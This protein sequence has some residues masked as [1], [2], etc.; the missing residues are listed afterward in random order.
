MANAKLSGSSGGSSP[1]SK[2][3]GETL[4]Q[5]ESTSLP[6]DSFSNGCEGVEFDF[7]NWVFRFGVDDSKPI[8]A[9]IWFRWAMDLGVSIKPQLIDNGHLATLI[10]TVPCDSAIAGAIA[11]GSCLREVYERSL[12]ARAA[13]L[14]DQFM[15]APPG[16]IIKRLPCGTEKHTQRY[17]ILTERSE[18]RGIAMMTVTGRNRKGTHYLTR[19]IADLFA[20]EGV[21]PSCETGGRSLA[22]HIGLS[23]NQLLL[24]SLSSSLDW[25]ASLN[26]VVLCS[27]T[28]GN[29]QLRRETDAISISDRNFEFESDLDEKLA[30]ESD[31][32]TAPVKKV[33][34]TDLLS[35]SRWQSAA[36]HIRPSYCQFVNASA[37]QLS[38]TPSTG[39]T[40]IFNGPDAYLRL[41]SRFSNQT[42]VVV[43]SRNADPN[44]ID[45]FM[46]I[47]H[48]VRESASL[49]E[50]S[51]P[52]PP[53]GIQLAC[54]GD[55]R[56]KEKQ[57]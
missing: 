47:A 7:Q 20:F 9:P 23:L 11:Y 44:K 22:P 31:Q 57:W 8:A 17:K 27:P 48:Y 6:R 56:M 45:R 51:L 28:Q 3:L 55:R 46:N 32:E 33:T 38:E 16:T 54:L 18:D 49:I 36:D 12:N 50:H 34:L 24:G 37:T 26:S 35:I 15:E 25:Y 21:N 29:T 39:S 53:F 13:H 30:D 2:K 19:D 40:V 1:E 41:N 4:V 52:L 14:F 43:I 42:Q 5:T 10:V